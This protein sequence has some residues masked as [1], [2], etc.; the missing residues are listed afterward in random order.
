MTDLKHFRYELDADGIALFTFDS[1]GASMNVLS[2][3]VMADLETIAG[4]ITESDEIKGVVFTSGKEAFCAGADL[5]TLFSGMFDEINALSGEAKLKRTYEAAAGM[6]ATFRKIETCGKPVAAAINGL[7]L[8][9]GLELTLACHHRVMADHPKAKVGLPEVLI[10]LFPGAGGT[11][12]LPRLIGPMDALQYMGQG[13]NFDAQSALQK[14]VVHEL[15][16]RDQVVERAKAWIRTNPEAK[17]PWDKDGFKLPGGRVYSPGGLQVFGGAGSMMRRETNGN[18]PAIR[19]MLS[20]VYEGLQ[21]PID[22]GLRIEA[23]YFAKLLLR[24]E[25]HAMIRSVFNS[26]QELEKGARRPAG[27]VKRDVNT[28]AVIGAGFMGAGIANVSAQAGVNVHLI[29]VDQAAAEKG[30]QHAAD[31]FAKRVAKGRASQEKADEVL[32]RINPTTDYSVLRE[33][34]LVVEA[35]FENSDLKNKITA[36]AEEHLPETSV[37]GTNTSTIPISGLAKAS[38]RPGNYL[39]VHFFSPV[40]KMLLVEI[41][42]GDETSDYAVSR[43]LDFVGKIKKTPIVVGDTRGFYANRCVLKFIDQGLTLLS[44]G[45]SPALIENASRMAGMPMGPMELMDMTAI[46]LGYKIMTQTKR[47]LGDAYVETP[48]DPITTRMYELGRYGRKTKTGFYDYGDDKSKKLWPDLDQFAVSGVLPEERQPDVTLVQERILF[49]QALEAAR[50]MEENVV[51][52]PREADVG[53]ILA[54]GF[55][56]FTGGVLSYIDSYGATSIGGPSGVAAFVARADELRAIAPGPVFEV[57][58]LLRD[59]A[60]RGETLYSR[61]G[62]AQPVAAE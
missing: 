22:A 9:G 32:A 6:Q 26:K 13:K 3:E 43:A 30:K 57:P 58:Q 54:W 53:S 48:A 16:P 10:G 7:A 25:S 41:I 27:E 17:A 20:A 61:F 42:R 5:K 44:E 29:D 33:V 4:A 35:V 34:D 56:P 37:F 2:A 46:D 60:A 8:G 1:P 49:C 39:G 52:D 45:V 11:Q 38:K 15:A 18:Y 40:E 62:A 55:A 59:L 21:V 50:C 24:P 47:D 19:Y 31:Y 23:R 28:I 12:R 14:G 36:A 51:E